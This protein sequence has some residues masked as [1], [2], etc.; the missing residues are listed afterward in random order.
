MKELP[1]ELDIG[2]AGQKTRMMGLSGRPR[3][4]TISSAVWMQSTNATDGRT[5]TG[6]QQRPRL[7]I[8][9]RG[10][11]VSRCR[12]K[13]SANCTRWRCDI[14]H[15]LYG[16]GVLWREWNLALQPRN[17]QSQCCWSK[18]SQSKIQCT[19]VRVRNGPT[20]LLAVT[21]NLRKVVTND[22]ACSAGTWPTTRPSSRT[23][24]QLCD[25]ISSRLSSSCGI[26]PTLHSSR[27]MG[28]VST[29]LFTIWQHATADK[30]VKAISHKLLDKLPNALPK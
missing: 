11:N 24:Y 17:K 19:L 29:I 20:S 18:S 9:S 25:V 7:C 10:E 30:N 28:S 2:A 23:E 12:L 16:G 6:R 14:R 3:N 4:L 22:S 5:N 15:C 27:V 8:A 21:F 13:V 1:S 26:I